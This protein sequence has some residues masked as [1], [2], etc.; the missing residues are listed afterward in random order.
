VVAL[1]DGEKATVKKFYVEGKMVRL[2]P[3]NKAFQPILVAPE[4]VTIQGIVVGIYR[5]T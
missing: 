5:K 3:A 4:R 2:Q 1:V